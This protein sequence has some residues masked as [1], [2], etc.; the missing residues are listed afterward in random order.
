M[1]RFGILVAL[2]VLTVVLLTGCG[3]SKYD[4]AL[5][6]IVDLQAQLSGAKADLAAAQQ[7]LTA[8]QQNLTTTL[9]ERDSIVKQ[10]DKAKAD[11]TVAQDSL[12]KSNN[13]LT[14]TRDSLSKISADYATAQQI[15]STWNTSV[16][17]YVSYVDIAAA[18]FNYEALRLKGADW[19]TLT[20]IAIPKIT[21]A[22]NA[23]QDSALINAYEIDKILW[24]ELMVK[25]LNELKPKT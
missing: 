20:Q 23:T 22:V 17:T 19:E 5:K 16:K 21:T 9:E 11:L 1:K 13:D 3:V 25:Q 8:A 14:A 10:L 15:L 24:F 2:L 7:N 18:H 6:E 4:T 12:S